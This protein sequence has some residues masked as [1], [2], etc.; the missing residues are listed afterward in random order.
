VNGAAEKSIPETSE[1][2][3]VTVN[4]GLAPQSLV[5]GWINLDGAGS[6]DLHFAYYAVVGP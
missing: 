3:T 2:L 6:N 4:G 5:Q 1:P